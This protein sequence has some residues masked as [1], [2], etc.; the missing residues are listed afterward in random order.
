MNF[1][2]FTQIYWNL[3]EFAVFEKRVIN[4]P[5]DR[6]TDESGS[7][8][9]AAILPPAQSGESPRND[10]SFQ[11]GLPFWFGYRWNPPST[12]RGGCSIGKA[13]LKMRLCQNELTGTDIH[14][15]AME[16]PVE[17]HL[18]LL[19]AQFLARALQPNHPSHLYVMQDQG[20]RNMKQT[21]HSKVLVDVRT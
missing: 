15:E 13:T 5:M 6:R 19:S 7:G 16:L 11:D 3:L 4:G 20:R 12:K 14:D 21:L 1:L 2:E 10:E 17:D 8:M 18:R 9:L